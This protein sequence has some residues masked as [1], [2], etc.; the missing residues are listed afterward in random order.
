MFGSCSGSTTLGLSDSR[1]RSPLPSSSHFNCQAAFSDGVGLE[2]DYVYV[3][4]NVG[5]YV[6]LIIIIMFACVHVC[7]CACM[8]VHVCVC[9]VLSRIAAVSFRRRVSF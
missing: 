3:F 4:V 5:M 7:M 6:Q 2:R 1:T 8:C 9:T